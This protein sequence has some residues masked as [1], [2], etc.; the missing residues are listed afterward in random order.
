[1]QVKGSVGHEICFLSNEPV[2]SDGRFSLKFK[3]FVVKGGWGNISLKGR[4]KLKFGW[5]ENSYA[6]K[7]CT[8]TDRS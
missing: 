2:P 4:A 7:A 8:S 1:M 3:V 6:L 5:K